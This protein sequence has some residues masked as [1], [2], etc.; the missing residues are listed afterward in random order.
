MIFNR[1]FAVK[2]KRTKEARLPTPR[3][4]FLFPQAGSLAD[5]LVPVSVMTGALLAAQKQSAAD[6]AQ[7]QEKATAAVT[8]AQKQSAADLAQAQEKVTA[9]VTAAQEKATAAVTAAQEKAMEKVEQL[10][11]DKEV[12]LSSLR[13]LPQLAVA[14]CFSTPSAHTCFPSPPTAAPP[15]APDERQG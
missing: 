2:D 13:A 7:A 15:D 11:R 4:H 10:N 5:P 14:A 6:L 1:R 9:A 3:L 8:A 12:L